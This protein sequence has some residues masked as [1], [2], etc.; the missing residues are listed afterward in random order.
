[1]SMTPLQYE[2]SASTKWTENSHRPPKGSVVVELCLPERY[3][4]VLTSA[5]VN[6][7]LFPDGSS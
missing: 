5:A 2:A 1:M 3:V 7:S 4:E 6:V